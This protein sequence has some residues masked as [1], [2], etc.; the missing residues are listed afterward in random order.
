MKSAQLKDLLLQEKARD[1]QF[2]DFLYEGGIHSEVE[3]KKRLNIV[4][5]VNCAMGHYIPIQ[6][7]AT[8]LI[9]AGHDVSIITNGSDDIKAKTKG[10]QERYGINL[11]YTDCGLTNEDA[12][13]KPKNMC[14]DPINTVHETWLPYVKDAIS[15][16][17]PDIIICDFFSPAGIFVADEMKIPVIIN[18]PGPVTFFKEFGIFTLPDMAET[19]NCCGLICMKKSLRI[20]CL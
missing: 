19:S 6:N 16:L 9:E 18:V 20:C 2:G 7:C 3:G 8:A 17:K 15:K 5:V 10:I 12:L 13:R 14:E 4:C 1:Q 11:I